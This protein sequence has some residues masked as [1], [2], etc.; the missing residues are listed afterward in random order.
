[1]STGG[2]FAALLADGSA[3]N[4]VEPKCCLPTSIPH[5]FVEVAR[6]ASPAGLLES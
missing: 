6:F 1:M 3:G 5:A 2:A 4:S